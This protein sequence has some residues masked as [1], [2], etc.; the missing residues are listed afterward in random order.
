M[1][2]LTL[3]LIP[4]LFGSFPL[5]GQL[6]P[7]C[8]A[9]S[10]PAVLCD[11][12]CINCNFNGYAGSTEGFPAAPAVDFCGTVENAQWLG[13]IAGE[14]QA[15]FTVT[16]SNCSAG[17]GVQVALY[18]DCTAPPLAC[19]KGEEGGGLL[20]VSISATL[21]PG[22][23]YF[24]LVDGYA[25][26]QCD[27]TISVTPVS[28]VFEPALGAAGALTGPSEICPGA[29][30]Q[31]SVQPA[32]GAGA[33]V[34]SGPPGTLINGEPAP[35]AVPAPGGT[36]VEVTM[37]DQGGELCVQA[38]NACNQNAPCTASLTLTPATNRPAIVADT[39]DHLTCT[40]EPLQL[41]LSVEPAAQYVAA[42]T[43]DSAG[44]L[45]TDSTVLLARVDREGTYTLT[46]TSPINGCTATAAIVVAGPEA[47]ASAIVEPRHATCYGFT[48]G[49]LR[50]AAVQG[51][52][53][54]YLFALD[55]EPF[56]SQME[57]VNLAPR[58]Y[59]LT[60]Q[61]SDGCEWDTLLVLT[62][63]DELLLTLD[64]DTMVH[65]GLPVGLWRDDQVNYPA[66]VA[67]R[68]VAPI[69]LEPMLCDS[70]LY[71]PLTSFHYRVTVLDSNGC[72]ASDERE[73]LVDR[74]RRVFFPNA[75]APGSGT[76]N[77]RFSVGAGPDVERIDRLRVYNRWGNLV[78][79]R[80][81]LDPGAADAG[82]DG[83]IE[84]RLAEPSVY[85][86]DAEVR[87][88]DGGSERYRGDVVLVR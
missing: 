41:T 67:Q 12:A 19:E 36:V 23:N 16:P 29:T 84:G 66:R 77:E 21:N 81:D 60:V 46:V 34:W 61:A 75:F 80:L 42:W 73:V 35:L 45:L 15:T 2:K 33:Y 55:D 82:W 6:P 53:P 83:R 70:C 11:L 58:E 17:D 7:A 86:Y 52:K 44:Q 9:G 18:G 10:Q 4:A 22:S 8:P 24:L 72:R 63:P 13:F 62:Q 64:P 54:P 27:F 39:L 71:E 38:V 68:L 5:Q 28:A 48:D 85:V 88:K 37:G 87:F 56:G 51:G 40:G 76:G 57:F 26:D 49:Q 47:P 32:L 43:A 31:Y 20:P 79:E 59:R 30:F 3:L 25:G 1:Q 78:F 14:S 74:S 69:E 65:L 50:I